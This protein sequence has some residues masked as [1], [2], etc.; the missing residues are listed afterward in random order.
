MASKQSPRVLVTTAIQGDEV[1]GMNREFLRGRFRLA[2]LV[3]F[4]VLLACVTVSVALG[5]NTPT[6]VFV[7]K[8]VGTPGVD[9]RLQTGNNPISISINALPAGVGV[10]D[11]FADS[12]GRSYVIAYDTGQDEPECPPG[13]GC[14]ENCEE[15]ETP[16]TTPRCPP[17]MTPTAG[18][19]GEPGN[20]ECEFPKTTPT[21]TPTA[22]VCPKPADPVVI[23]KT[24]TKVV[25]KVKWRT[26]VVVKW[27]TRVVYKT[28]I[29]Y[30][31]KKGCPPGYRYSE[32][33]GCTGKV[34]A[35]G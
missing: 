20:D 18:K 19:D 27:R 5:T 33:F 12:Q 2:F 22:P 21:T 35:N 13:E 10:G 34:P 9:E 4:V 25:T 1:R 30:K 15:P 11:S 32:R 16:P 6:K 31:T 23:T 14:K 3:G 28:K 17:G 8:Y 26:R 24:E 29:V 7:C